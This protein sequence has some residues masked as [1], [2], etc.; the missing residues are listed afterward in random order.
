MRRGGAAVGARAAGDWAASQTTCDPGEGPGGESGSGVPREPCTQLG[1]RAPGWAGRGH[2]GGGRPQVAER[3]QE[4]LRGERR[5]WLRASSGPFPM[6][7]LPYAPSKGSLSPRCILL[8]S[9]TSFR[10]SWR[11]LRE[12]IVAS[13]ARHP[14]SQ[15]LDP[16]PSR[17][18]HFCAGGGRR[19]L[20]KQAF[21]RESANLTHC[22]PQPCRIAI[23]TTPLGECSG[24]KLLLPGPSPLHGQSSRPSLSWFPPAP[25]ATES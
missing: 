21:P 22:T 9:W 2:L 7:P 19:E 16:Q 13:W 14:P 23:N 1:Q 25:G 24:G 8:P 11:I 18:T 4:G 17:S 12:S 6:R 20:R 5:G 3:L 10:C 15:L